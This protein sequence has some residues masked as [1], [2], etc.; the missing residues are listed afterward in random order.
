MDALQMAVRSLLYI[1]PSYF[2]NSTPVALGGGQPLD[3]NRKLGDGQRVFGDGKT[4]RGFFAGIA[5]GTL[6]GA[7][8]GIA[9]PGSSLDIYAA[10]ASTYVVGGFLLASG[11]MVGDLAGSFIKRRLKIARGKPSLAL[12]QLTFLLFALLFSYP[13]A[14]QL[15]T[16]ESVAFLAVL[17]YFVHIAANVIAH[18]W[19]LKKVPW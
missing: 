13:L 12:D 17:T 16:A 7:V 10:G 1:L 4:V 6:V 11:T 9:L 19:G 2:A 5:A 3:G 15:L 18:R 8:E 14:A